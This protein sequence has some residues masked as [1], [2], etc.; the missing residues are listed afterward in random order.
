MNRVAVGVVASA[1]VALGAWYYLR[2]QRKIYALLRS[3]KKLHA[4]KKFED[5]L[6]ASE[7]ACNLAEERLAGSSVHIVKKNWMARI[8]TR[9]ARQL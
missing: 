6:A 7:E 3:S 5:S 1:A 9:L 4:D 8:N 2:P